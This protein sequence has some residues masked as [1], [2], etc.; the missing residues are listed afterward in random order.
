M[1]N[2]KMLRATKYVSAIILFA[3]IT[4]FHLWILCKR[5]Q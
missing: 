2:E 5:L 4:M 3:G 1:K